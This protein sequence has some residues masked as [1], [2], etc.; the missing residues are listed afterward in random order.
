MTDNEELFRMALLT[1]ALYSFFFFFF[2]QPT[3]SNLMNFVSSLLDE[4]D[5]VLLVMCRYEEKPNE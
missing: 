1:T 5:T 4:N 2:F 3:G